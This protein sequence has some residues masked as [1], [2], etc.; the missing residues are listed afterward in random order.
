[1]NEFLQMSKRAIW[2]PSLICLHNKW[3]RLHLVPELSST[4]LVVIIAVNV[5]LDK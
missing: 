1:M 3:P 5:Y 2:L 4:H